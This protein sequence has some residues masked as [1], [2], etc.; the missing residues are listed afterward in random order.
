VKSFVC[1]ACVAA[2]ALPALPWVDRAVERFQADLHQNLSCTAATYAAL[3]EDATEADYERAVEL[4]P[5]DPDELHEGRPCG[6]PSDVRRW[7]ASG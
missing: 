6:R 3:E 5:E 1:L 4:C 7:C 2:I